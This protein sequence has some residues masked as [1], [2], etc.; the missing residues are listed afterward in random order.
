MHV[1]EMQRAAWQGDPNC[2]AQINTNDNA[3]EP[4]KLQARRISRLYAVSFAT[5]ATIARLAYA[6]GAP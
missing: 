5:A 6:V 1:P 2:S 4:T 3:T